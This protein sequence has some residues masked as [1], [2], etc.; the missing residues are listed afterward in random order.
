MGHNPCVSVP[1]FSEGTKRTL[2][3]IE[4][5]YRGNCN[6]AL[7]DS[8][9]DLET[10]Y[11]IVEAVQEGVDKYFEELQYLAEK[12]KSM[13]ENGFEVSLSIDLSDN[14]IEGVEETISDDAE[15]IAKHVNNA[16]QKHLGG[17]TQLS[18]GLS[19][20]GE[21]SS[22]GKVRLLFEAG[23]SLELSIKKF[24]TATVAGGGYSTGVEWDISDNQVDLFSNWGFYFMGWDFEHS[25]KLKGGSDNELNIAVHLSAK[26]ISVFFIAAIPEPLN[27]MGTTPNSGMRGS[28]S[29]R[30]R[31][32]QLLKDSQAGNPIPQTLIYTRNRR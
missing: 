28:Y 13:K 20:K 24:A 22:E 11:Q 8:N 14:V 4:F 3:D 26:D 10:L 17:N 12:G 7:G 2:N 19:I 32:V 27:Y 1:D 30:L 21:I 23:S 31:M 6:W 5:T 16:I 18:G 9:I 29:A 15:D 25:D